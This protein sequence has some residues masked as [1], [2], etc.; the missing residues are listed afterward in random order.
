LNHSRRDFLAGLTTLAVTEEA[1]AAAPAQRESDQDAG[2]RTRI[3]LADLIYDHPVARSEEGMPVGNGRMGT[4]VWT[5]PSEVRLQINRV[6][7]YANNSYSNSFIERHNDYCGGCAYV[8]IDFGASQNEVF[9][10]P[11]FQQRLSV[12]EGVMSLAGKQTSLEMIAWPERDVIAAQVR[13][14]SAGASPAPV[15]IRLRM[16]RKA[17][18]YF[19]GELETFAREHIAAVETRSHLAKCQL[20]IEGERIVLTQEFTED[21]YYNKSAVVIALEGQAAKAEIVNETDV[22]LTAHIGGRLSTILIGSA[23]TFDRGADVVREALDQIDAA[24]AKGYAGL[25]SETSE[26][27]SRFWKLGSV[28]L[29]SPDG[30]AKLIEANYH[31]F[32]YVM[33]ASSRGMYPPKF[34]GMLWNTGGDLRTWGAQ[35][36]FANTSC[37]YEALF[38]ANR[39]DLLNPFFDMYSGML[40]ACSVAAHQQWGTQGMYIPE[41][42]YFDGLEKLPED[43]ASEMRE[44]Y[45]M[46]KPWAE[47]SERFRSY[48]ETKHPHS[49]RWNWMETGKWVKGRWVITERGAGPYGNVNHIFGTTAKI[50]YLYWRRFE[51]TQDRAWLRERAYPMLRAAAE[52]YRNHP[53]VQKEA[54][55]KFHIRYAN[56]NE[57]VWGAR[58]TDEDLSAMRGVFAALLRASELLEVEADMRPVWAG[59]LRDLAELPTTNDPGALKPA[60]YRGPEVFVRGR[61]PAVKAGAGVLPDP[62]SLPQWFFDLCN[63]GAPRAEMLAL[64]NKTF[65]SYFKKGIDANTPVSVLSKLAIAGATLGRPEAVRYLIPNQ[66]R[67]IRPERST[68]YRNGGVLANR[69]TLR[70]GPQALDAQRLGRAA[71][72]LHIALLQSAPTEP[73]GEPVIRLFAA[74]P[75]DWDGSFQLLARGGFLVRARFENGAVAQVQLR[76]FAGAECRIANPWLGRSVVLK[77]DGNR[78]ETVEGE[79]LRFP[80]KQDEVIE[81]ARA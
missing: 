45:L 35:H 56:S 78:T 13:T 6:D 59:F 15:E 22:R 34:N 57:S 58:D 68:A 31:Y 26:W 65:D 49:S 73:G 2:L 62:N 18:Q 71:E 21:D 42:V 10:A 28:E 20:R 74:W 63:A 1:R 67:A 33:G 81:L 64:A 47:R 44:L 38:T 54:D 46:R 4:L 53:N 36:W 55:G 11:A 24:A 80:S 25:K 43:V 72:A 30:T 51:F 60:E 37:Y 7:V 41:T 12:Y 29:E 61:R 76:S 19:G 69:M 3:S 9:V 27:W 40:E 14:R 8:D 77:R 79:L 16:L 52:F 39:L 5:T 17:S 50:A 70:E 66:I 75:K 23:S 48:A 32:L